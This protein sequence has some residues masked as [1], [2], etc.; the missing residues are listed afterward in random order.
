MFKIEEN[1]DITSL[2]TF[3][4][5]VKARYFAEYTS[6]KELLKISRTDEFINSNLLNIGGGS[7][8][9]FL[10]D[11]DGLVLH[12]AIRGILRYEK[13]PDTVFAIAGAGVKWTDFVDWCLDENLA[14]VENLA[15]IPGEVG[16]SAVQNVGAYG[17]EAKDVIHS[18]ECFDVMTRETVRFTNEECHFG[19]RDSFFKHEGKGRY[20]ILRVAFR[21]V[22]GG[23]PESLDYGPL[24]DLEAELGRCP[25]IREVAQKVTEIRN[26]K[27]PDPNLI[28]S[29][30]SFFKNPV[31]RARYL[32]EI[33]EMSGEKIPVHEA[34]ENYV[35]LSAAWLID[36]A[37]L[38]SLKVGGAALCPTQPLVIINDDNATADDIM[39]LAE[40]IS[41]GVRKKYFVTL[42]PEVN[43]IDTRIKVTVLGSGTSKGIPEIGC[44]CHVCTSEDSH[45]NRMRASIYVE[46]MGLKILIDASPDF[47]EQ[48][49][50]NNIT[51][52]DAVLITH[53]HND[54]V[55]GIDDLR[56]FC[57]GRDNS[58][59]PMYVREDV[60][61]DLRQRLSYCF[62]DV[63]YPGVPTFDM[64]VIDNKDFYINGIKITPIE[65]MHGKMPIYGYRIGNFAYITDAKTISEEEKEKLYGVDTLIV[66]ALRQRNH[67]AHFTLQEALDLIAEVKPRVAYLTHM[68]HEIGT[69]EELS[70]TLPENVKPAYDGQVIISL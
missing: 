1:K 16:A 66:N 27:L 69:H 2:T 59:L 5:P 15:D 68:C 36:H 9:L 3:G 41:Y 4:I 63:H 30:G 67:F 22:P 53:R 13:T 18:V 28:G 52:I 20:I 24:R 39:K 64:R 48:A 45:D 7:N 32:Q 37:G 44:A 70:K 49:L 29:A 14:G 57:M 8:L 54:H 62:S 60:G 26:S 34:G 6:E 11:Y 19:Y 10:T 17:V 46:T 25:T 40:K 35:K 47:R 31:V 55:G 56:P 50:R 23:N 43:Y 12:S 42:H 51:D 33:E 21:L 61:I 65:V 58:R 38:K